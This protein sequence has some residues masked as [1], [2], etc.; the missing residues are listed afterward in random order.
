MSFKRKGKEQWKEGEGA[1]MLW[2]F[3]ILPPASRNSPRSILFEQWYR[4]ILARKHERTFV[5]CKCHIR[6]VVCRVFLKVEPNPVRWAIEGSASARPTGIT[7]EPLVDTSPVKGAPRLTLYQRKDPLDVRST[8]H[9][10]SAIIT[11]V[12]EIFILWPVSKQLVVVPTS[13][14]GS[15][16]HVSGNVMI[17]SNTPSSPSQS[18]ITA[19]VRVSNAHGQG[20]YPSWFMTNWCQYEPTVNSLQLIPRRRRSNALISSR[21]SLGQHENLSIALRTSTLV[22]INWE[23]P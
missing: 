9:A 12:L 2:Y 1:T 3:T 19:A 14:F 10:A 5:I 6:D 17:L 18:L 23:F 11:A 13:L 7:V 16:L 15:K 4:Q 22:R 20:Y 21:I 8:L